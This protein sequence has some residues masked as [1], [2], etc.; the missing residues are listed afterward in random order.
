MATV[1]VVIV[2]WARDWY[3]AIVRLKAPTLHESP[4]VESCLNVHAGADFVD[5]SLRIIS[6]SSAGDFSAAAEV[7]RR[8]RFPPVIVNSSVSH[9]RSA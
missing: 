8:D 2:A 1:L 3:L 6:S 9:M 5:V 4:Y 7:A